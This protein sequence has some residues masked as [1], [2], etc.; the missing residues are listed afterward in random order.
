MVL[1]KVADEVRLLIETAGETKHRALFCIFGD[2]GDKQVPNLYQALETLRGTHGSNKKVLWVYKEKPG[3]SS[4]TKKRNKE[5][6]SLK[7]KGEMNEQYGELSSWI[8]TA[9]RQ[10]VKYSETESVLGQ[11]FDMLVLQDFESL[12]PNGICRTMETVVGGGIIIMLFKGIEDV[13]TL[14]TLSVQQARDVL[15]SKEYQMDVHRKYRTNREEGGLAATQIGDVVGR[16]MSRMFVSFGDVKHSL[17]V[18][19][20]LNVIPIND[21]ADVL[22]DKVKQRKLAESH[23]V[24]QKNDT[25]QTFAPLALKNW[26]TNFDFGFTNDSDDGTTSAYTSL[27]NECATAG[28]AELFKKLWSELERSSINSTVSVTAA[29]GRGKSAA[30]GIAISAALKLG[31]TN[32]FV[33]SPHPSNV[34]T[35]FEFAIK[36][37]KI[38][39]Y[40]EGVDFVVENK[41][42]DKMEKY[43]KRDISGRDRHHSQRG[44]RTAVFGITLKGKHP[45]RVLY[46]KPEE[47]FFS[48]DL[49]VLDECAAIPLTTVKDILKTKA[50]SIL[51]STVYGYEGTGRALSLKLLET[52]GTNKADSS[53]KLRSHT[54]ITLVEP[55]RY[56]ENDPIEQWLSELLCLDCVDPVPLQHGNTPS[57][58]WRLYE[59]NRDVLFSGN[60][61][62]EALLTRI[63]S[64]FVSSH[65]KNSPDD[66]MMLADSP[67]QRLYMLCP[68][69]RTNNKGIPD[70]YGVVQGVLEG[71]LTASGVTK[72]RYDDRQ[73][74]GN[75]IPWTLT[76]FYNDSGFAELVGLRVQRIAVHPNVMRR[77]V[78]TKLIK[79]LEEYLH[80]SNSKVSVLSTASEEDLKTHGRNM[81]YECLNEKAYKPTFDFTISWLGAAF[82]ITEPLFDFWHRSESDGGIALTPVFLGTE[83][84]SITGEYSSIMVKGLTKEGEWIDWF[85]TKFKEHLIESVSQL[86]LSTA[87][88]LRLLGSEQ[89]KPLTGPLRGML[90]IISEEN[91]TNFYTIDDIEALRR[92]LNPADNP[93]FASIR[94]LTPRLARDFYSRRLNPTPALIN[95]LGMLILVGVGLQKKGVGIVAKEFGLSE[96]PLFDGYGEMIRVFAKYLDQLSTAQLSK[97]PKVKRS[98]KE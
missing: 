17:F 96:N 4:N 36:S 52:L 94:H 10:F 16:F 47:N 25:H 60:R 2:H 51:S 71:H 45:R 61:H 70:V 72:R 77:G 27:I 24:R 55:I 66:L 31:F 91:I 89:L 6:K 26:K 88:A 3:L 63:M 42:M 59:V 33:S 20:E 98:K 97:G 40:V 19:D 80:F 9:K 53:L 28:Q 29:R 5:L 58:T 22:K 13:N 12:T 38:M 32:I 64:L 39:G 23:S 78:G 68:D 83:P 82:G 65:Y 14:H 92:F 15:V 1:K 62:S 49:I 56:A 79:K 76:N 81:F 30:L 84:N 54:P 37:L 11:T 7:K 87:L 34:A 18:D 93:A 21:Y 85:T 57:D 90:P 35:L 8:K 75:L 41:D 46:Q 48:A 67:T 50:M 73:G 44:S 74:D 95:K 43:K 86:K 69:I